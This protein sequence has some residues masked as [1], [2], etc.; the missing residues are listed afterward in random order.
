[1]RRIAFSILLTVSGC[2]AASPS[3]NG[4]GRIELRY[5][6]Y[7]VAHVRADSFEGAG[8]GYGLAVARD[9]LCL[10]E[11]RFITLASERSL[12]LAPDEGYLDPFAGG[13]IS[14]VDS[15]A[16]YL[17]LLSPEVIARVRSAASADM[18]ALVRGYV[19]G[20]NLHASHEV[21]RG[22]DCRRQP[23]FRPITE[24]DVWRRIAHVPLL[25]TTATVLRE[26]AAAAP[27]TQVSQN[28]LPDML[29]AR[30]AGWEIHGAS[31][32]VAFGRE[33]VAG[34]VGGLS[35]ANPHYAW[36]G[37]ERLHAFHMTVPGKLDV[38][39]ATALGLPFP[40][41]GFTPDVGWGITHTTDRRST[42]YELTLDPADPTRY[43]LDGVSRP[44]TRVS[45]TVP[46]RSGKVERTFWETTFGSVI[47]GAQLPWDSKRAY[48]FADPE[49]Q[50]STFADQFL[51]IARARS[52]REVKQALDAHLGSPWS[53]VTAADRQGEALYAN[54]S[55]AAF[56]TDA[57]F[58][59]CT[60]RGAARAFMDMADVTVLDGARSACAWTS[61]PRAPRR[62]I[63]PAALRPSMFRRDVV[64]NSNDS[65][66]FDTLAPD[67]RLTGYLKVI[68]PEQA[69]RG[70][71]TRMAAMM[72]REMISTPAADG[73]MG[74]TPARWEQAFFA[75]RNL[76]AELTLPDLLSDCMANPVVTQKSGKTVDV[77]AACGVLARWDR[78]DTL[79]S[80]GSALFAEFLR[81]L[82][83][84]PMTGFALDARYWKRTFDPA[85]PVNTPSGLVVS[86]ETREALAAAVQRFEA[87]HVAIDAPLKD[88]QAVTR[89]GVRLPMSG[90]SFAYH[91]V[92]P[93]AFE[94]HAG[95]TE[96]RAGDSYIHLVSLLS[97]GPRGRFIVTY[98]QS[99]NPASP[100][101][102]DMTEVFS[103]QALLD[104]P[105]SFADVAAAQV[106]ATEH[107]SVRSFP[108][109]N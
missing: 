43:I 36:H 48:V 34:G 70:E 22:E 97:E 27:A 79:D 54:I 11:D 33:G 41:L 13:K 76:T 106:G 5:T 83:A 50:N 47:E 69:V 37:A 65:H 56:I 25:E 23:W 46:T 15:D 32:A 96:I 10:I 28:A 3:E 52:V 71:R 18:K 109:T 1:M 99:T 63:V 100:H 4:A 93:G 53:N 72:A 21:A 86:Q 20:F 66:W 59:D 87:A 61:D 39:G 80:R 89:N 90:S 73:I 58:E 31:N 51:S 55:V 49:R 108:E 105:F 77:S 84:V 12:F 6:A 42:L 75:A 68:G 102:S 7:G 57:Q 82:D 85:D 8:Y 107:F 103:R 44:M 38:F 19:A 67:A 14:N 60:V 26:A 91:L 2:V 98:S 40:M 104:V 29:A 24:D 9:N 94:P 101:F 78:R 95:I 16:A 74:V 45:V 64:W 81:N 30:E 35:F 88:V 17:Y 92:R 62:G